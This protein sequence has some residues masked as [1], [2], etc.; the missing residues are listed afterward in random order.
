MFLQK[1]FVRTC[2]ISFTKE[3]KSLFKILRGNKVDQKNKQWLNAKNQTQWSLFWATDSIYLPR[4]IK[5]MAV[6]I[7]FIQEMDALEL[8]AV[9]NK[10]NEDIGHRIKE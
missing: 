2:Y 1:N 8:S 4:T 7:I 9:E 3:K 6:I 5:E 10:D